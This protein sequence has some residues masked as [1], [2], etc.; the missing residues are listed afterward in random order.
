LVYVYRCPELSSG[1][2]LFV[3]TVVVLLLLVAEGL[4]RGRVGRAWMAIRGMDVAA[5]TIAIRRLRTKLLA[6]LRNRPL[7]ISMRK[8][9]LR[10]AAL[11]TL[12]LPLS[13]CIFRADG[14]F[15]TD[16]RVGNGGGN[17]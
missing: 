15:G 14:E 11:T 7:Q 10:A 2:I 16:R 8:D 6:R 4:M 5:K 3:L 9:V 12:K 13:H 17:G 1:R